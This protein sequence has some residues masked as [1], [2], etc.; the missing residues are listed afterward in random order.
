MCV[1]VSLEPERTKMSPVCM[2]VRTCVLLLFF[3][4][5]YLM[6]SSHSEQQKRNSGKNLTKCVSMFISSGYNIVS[7]IWWEF[8]SS[9]RSVKAK[10]GY[11]TSNTTHMD[12]V[13]EWQATEK[14][15]RFFFWKEK[16]CSALADITDN[17]CRQFKERQKS[18]SYTIKCSML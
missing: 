2:S 17:R 10:K 1:L 9:L 8:F 13:F 12:H 3:L 16:N 5:R 11:N 6:C 14:W 7:W 15:E 4:S 18:K